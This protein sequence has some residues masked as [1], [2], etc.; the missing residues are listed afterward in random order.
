MQRSRPVHTNN[1]IIYVDIKHWQLGSLISDS[2]LMDI[3]DEYRLTLKTFDIV[4][5]FNL[6]P[7]QIITNAM[8]NSGHS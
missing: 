6:V 1:R 8:R 4:S 7:H 5:I 2:G 3:I